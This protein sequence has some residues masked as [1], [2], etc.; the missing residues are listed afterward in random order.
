MSGK[1]HAWRDAYAFSL[2]GLNS[3]ASHALMPA[4]A[5]D[6]LN[7]VWDERLRREREAQPDQP[8]T[9]R[10]MAVSWGRFWLR[11]RRRAA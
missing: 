7:K 3:I 8:D 6:Y 5:H 10:E 9:A 1:P 11:R 2:R 4:V